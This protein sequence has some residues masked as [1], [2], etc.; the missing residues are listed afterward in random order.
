TADARESLAE[1]EILAAL[2]RG[3]GFFHASIEVAIGRG[4]GVQPRPQGWIADLRQDHLAIALANAVQERQPQTDGGA[5]GAEDA[6]EVD[7]QILD[8]AGYQ[9]EVADDGVERPAGGT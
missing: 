5:V 1:D 3:I 7:D 9:Q 6:F 8:V 4:A 2:E